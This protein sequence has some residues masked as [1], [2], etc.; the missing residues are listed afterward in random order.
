MDPTMD[1]MMWLPCWCC[2]HQPWPCDHPG[3]CTPSHASL[4]PRMPATHSAAP[5]PGGATTD[6]TNNR[7]APRCLL[8]QALPLQ[9]AS[10]V[11][12]EPVDAAATHAAAMWCWIQQGRARMRAARLAA[13]AIGKRICVAS[14]QQMRVR[15]G[16]AA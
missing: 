4:L 16:R 13:G 6:P 10:R 3:A 11:L 5:V 14:S 9:R 15:V 1:P 8:L 2:C 7:S 12:Q